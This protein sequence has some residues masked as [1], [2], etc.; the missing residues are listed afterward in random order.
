MINGISST[1]KHD[2][3]F[4]AEVFATTPQRY[5]IDYNV[6]IL[7]YNA[8]T[9]ASIV[10]VVFAIFSGL[11]AIPS[12]FLFFSVTSAA[13]FY[14]RD[15]LRKHLNTFV[16]MRV[17]NSVSSTLSGITNRIS[18]L[19][20]D[21]DVVRPEHEEVL[22]SGDFG[23]FSMFK[24]VTP[25]STLVSSFVPSEEAATEAF[26]QRLND[27][28]PVTHGFVVCLAINTYCQDSLFREHV[29]ERRRV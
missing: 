10:S 7:A 22:G 26:K 4:D 24:R 18:R 9:V 19:L 21:S 27:A 3:G 14:Q 17:A 29:H 11:A 6:T 23:W 2:L 1:I 5:L 25:F 16:T 15:E 8:A 28:T 20:T 12:G 13:A